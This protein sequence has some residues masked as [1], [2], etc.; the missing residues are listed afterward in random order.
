[1]QTLLLQV[2]LF[3]TGNYQFTSSHFLCNR[4]M[5]YA[6]YVR[7]ALRK[8][9]RESEVL[10]LDTP[11]GSVPLVGGLLWFCTARMSSL[12]SRAEV[13][14]SDRFQSIGDIVF[15]EQTPKIALSSILGNRSRI[16]RTHVRQSIAGLTPKEH[17][18]MND[19]CVTTLDPLKTPLKPSRSD[20]RCQLATAD[21]A[22]ASPCNDDRVLSDKDI[23]Q[24]AA[25]ARK[26]SMRVPAR[27]KCATDVHR[28]LENRHRWLL[29]AQHCYTCSRTEEDCD[30]GKLCT[31]G[32]KTLKHVARCK[33]DDCSYP[34]CALLKP[35]LQ[36]SRKCQSSSCAICVPVWNYIQRE[37]Q[38][39]EEQQDAQ[40]AQ[41]QRKALRRPSPPPHRQRH[42]SS[43]AADDGVSRTR[44][45]P[46]HPPSSTGAP[47][48]GSAASDPAVEQRRPE[49]ELCGRSSRPE[50]AQPGSSLAAGA[51]GGLPEWEA[52]GRLSYTSTPGVAGCGTA[53]S[54]LG[55]A[56]ECG[57]QQGGTSD[58]KPACADKTRSL[59]QQQQQPQTQQQVPREQQTPVQAPGAVPDVRIEPLQCA[60]SQKPS[61]VHQAQQQI[62]QMPQ[63]Q[64]ELAQLQQ[65]H[66]HQPIFTIAQPMVQHGAAAAITSAVPQRFLGV[67]SGTLPPYTFASY[68][69][70]LVTSLVPS[71]AEIT[72]HRPKGITI[73]A[74]PQQPIPVI[75][76]TAMHPPPP[77]SSSSQQLQVVH[78]YPPSA[79]LGSFYSHLSQHHP[80]HPGG[81]TA[82]VATTT[83]WLPFPGLTAVPR[84][85]SVTPVATSN[86]INGVGAGNGG[87][88]VANAGAAANTATAAGP[89]APAAWPSQGPIASNPV[90][91]YGIS[92]DGMRTGGLGTVTTQ[93]P[94]Q[95][96]DRFS[97]LPYTFAGVNG[98]GG[99]PA[100][101]GAMAIA[102]PPLVLWPHQ[103]AGAM[104]AAGPA[105]VSG[106]QGHLTAHLP[107]TYT[108]TS[109]VSA[110]PSSG[111][112]VLE[113]SGAAAT[114]PGPGTS[115]TQG[116][117]V[118]PTHSVSTHRLLY[119]PA[120]IVPSAGGA[121]AAASIT[122]SSGAPVGVSASSTGPVADSA[123]GA[124][125]WNYLVQ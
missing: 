119:G 10:Q 28:A 39:Q 7:R 75:S 88:F 87:L 3:G 97:G 90:A 4:W 40:R 100:A 18:A 42:H 61:S 108:V 19:V 24:P 2:T 66:Q 62:L 112:A 107:T 65:S 101:A 71:P 12:G 1:M 50:D 23:I 116:S 70:G 41:H 37:L 16:E 79:S 33:R 115:S 92:A 60:H 45:V 22:E 117:A 82:T 124:A 89:S 102:A 54:H 26:A 93:G 109:T 125:H 72:E 118:A 14:C 121:S 67:A 20:D 9:L 85:A 104:A 103:P 51:L 68:S 55:G 94:V 43:A 111:T 106:A 27:V 80:K 53:G 36:H 63:K 6:I 59:Q 86:G 38:Q 5:N 110:R 74:A 122:G 31:Y 95:A 113:V 32:K 58:V 21:H 69:G 47:P 25:E 105:V 120:G 8:F 78:S 96:V 49:D 99:L 56:L 91:L 46:P 64:Q 13:E 11:E 44:W 114:P 98:G 123:T 34:R 30:L 84:G 57:K 48:G 77:A 76:C 29:F 83:H 17:Q 52:A 35:L 73:N 15:T 81:P